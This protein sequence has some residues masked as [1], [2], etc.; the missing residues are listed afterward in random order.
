MGGTAGQP[1]ERVS[2]PLTPVVLP[3]HRVVAGLKGKLTGMAFRVPLAN[4]SVV[5]LTC[6]LL[7]V[8]ERPG[9]APLDAAPAC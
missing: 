1:L 7:K 8:M 9:G 5:D 6:R 4:V 2:T 3:A